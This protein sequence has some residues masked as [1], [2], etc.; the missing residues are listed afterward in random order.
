VLK[1]LQEFPEFV[2]LAVGMESLLGEEDVCSRQTRIA[3]E[4]DVT[5][6]STVGSHSNFYSCFWRSFS[7]E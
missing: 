5:F 7:L 4:N 2:F 1:F 6:Y 3:V